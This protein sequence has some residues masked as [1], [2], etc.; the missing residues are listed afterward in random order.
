MSRVALHYAGAKEKE[1]EERSLE[2]ER[3]REKSVSHG[4]ER[5]PLRDPPKT[6]EDFSLATTDFW[7][8]GCPMRREEVS[9]RTGSRAGIFP[10]PL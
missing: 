7:A 4:G 6:G 3:V 5:Y 2:G 1:A 10:I 9:I 8:S